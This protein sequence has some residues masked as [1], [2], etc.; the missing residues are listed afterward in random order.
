[1]KRILSPL[2]GRKRNKRSWTNSEFS[3]KQIKGRESDTKAKNT[4]NDSNEREQ[5]TDH[6]IIWNREYGRCTFCVDTRLWFAWQKT[7]TWSSILDWSTHSSW[8]V[9]DTRRNVNMRCIRWH[10]MS[11][12]VWYLI[13]ESW[14]DNNEL[15]RTNTFWMCFWR[16][17]SGNRGRREGNWMR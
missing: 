11:M 10:T 5:G 12:E 7:T 17:E 2:I 15:M 3:N 8:T 13:Y 14:M 16:T 9:I 6:R 4:G 1:M